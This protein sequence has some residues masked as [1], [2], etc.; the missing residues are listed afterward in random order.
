MQGGTPRCTVE[1]ASVQSGQDAGP[2]SSH[3]A[4][5]T[6]ALLGLALWA[7]KKASPRGAP[8]DPLSGLAGQRR[9]GLSV[10]AAAEMV[11]RASPFE[12]FDH[13]IDI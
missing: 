8:P 1:S 6:S 2:V 9:E 7:W 11:A 13:Q 4:G 3:V 12:P 5:R 10:A